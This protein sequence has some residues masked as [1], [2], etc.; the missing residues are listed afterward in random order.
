[1][2]NKN[3]DGNND[4]NK[5]DSK[6]KAGANNNN[7]M[8]FTILS[9]SCC[10]PAFAVHDQE[11]V[12]RIN[13]ALDSI[14]YKA[15]IEILPA[16][17]AFFGSKSGYIGKLVPLF[18]KHGMAVAPALFINEELVLYGGLPS[19]EK[20]IQVIEKEKKKS[21]GSEHDYNNRS[22]NSKV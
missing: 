15:Q 6:M 9:L 16:T 14:N 19:V 13:K 7:P 4:G 3:A 17:D 1:M 22:V 5:R 18:N 12:S 21:Q 2:N 20:I 8:K 11:Y 10:N